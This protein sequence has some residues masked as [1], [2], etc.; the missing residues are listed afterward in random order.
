MLE[1]PPNRLRGRHQHNHIQK[2]TEANCRVPERANEMCMAWARTHGAP[3]ATEK[4]PLMHFTRRPKRLKMQATVRIPEFQDGPLPVMKI[5]ANHLGS[6]L[7]WGPRVNLTTAK[8]RIAHGVD[9]SVDQEHME[10]PFTK[11]RQIYA[12]VVRPVLSYG[13][14]VWY[15]LGDERANRNRLIYPVTE[16][17]SASEPLKVHTR[18]QMPKF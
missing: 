7:K 12:A 10:T 4:H 18:R 3:F 9:H 1:R 13:C 8:G 11:P 15:S 2:I 14:S 16:Q 6:K 17:T 5:L